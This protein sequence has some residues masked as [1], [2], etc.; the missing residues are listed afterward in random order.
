[1]K[2][3][4]TNVQLKFNCQANWDEMSNTTGGKNCESCQKKVFDFTQGSHD[5]FIKVLEENNYNVCGRFTS[6]QASVPEQILP[7]WKRWASAAM[8]LIGFNLFNGKAMSQNT[9]PSTTAQKISNSNVS[10][11]M[12]G[13]VYIAPENRTIHATP[14][15]GVDVFNNIIRKIITQKEGELLVS[16]DID[17][18][19]NIREA[20]IINTPGLKID[21]LTERKISEMFK[22]AKWNPSTRGG[23]AAADE[24]L[25]TISLKT[26]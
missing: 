4:I 18:Q 25:Y 17:M 16:I 8:V 15:I 19:S 26:N 12:L 10:S 7:Y 20:I 21:S 3:P 11:V 2:K 6:Q 1:M 23:R 5:D 22:Q 9:G 24:F 14:I 13:E